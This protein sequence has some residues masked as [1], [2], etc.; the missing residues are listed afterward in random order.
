LLERELEDFEAIAVQLGTA[1]RGKKQRELHKQERRNRRRV[2]PNEDEVAGGRREL[3]QE[4]EYEQP[5][6]RAASFRPRRK[7]EDR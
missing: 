7:K 6:K 4:D 2:E 3:P 1:G 5:M